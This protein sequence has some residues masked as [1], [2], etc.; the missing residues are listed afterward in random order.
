MILFPTAR[1]GNLPINIRFD[2][3][4]TYRAIRGGMLIATDVDS[5]QPDKLFCSV[6]D[7]SVLD[8]NP[9]RGF[10]KLINHLGSQLVRM[11]FL[12]ERSNSS[13]GVTLQ[14]SWDPFPSASYA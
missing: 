6:H 8:Q 12:S 3:V 9:L 13:R 4:I 2:D 11:V 1:F 10:V 7:K 14:E 5:P